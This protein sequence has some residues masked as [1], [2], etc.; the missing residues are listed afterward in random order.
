MKIALHIDR[1]GEIRK[2]LV[3]YFQYVLLKKE[4]H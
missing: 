2:M 4:E 1:F 3:D